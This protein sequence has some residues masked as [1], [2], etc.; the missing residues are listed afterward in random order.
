MADMTV[1]TVT[2]GRRGND[3]G[4]RSSPGNVNDR[5]GRSSRREASEGGDRVRL[6]S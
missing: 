2:I 6:H 4:R 1:V 5:Y 3:G